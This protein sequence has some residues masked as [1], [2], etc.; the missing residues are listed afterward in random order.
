[1]DVLLRWLYHDETL[2]EIALH[3]NL[4]YVRIR[5]L[6]MK[7]L[8]TLRGIVYPLLREIDHPT[9]APPPDR[10]D[11]MERQEL[12]IREMNAE[13]RYRARLTD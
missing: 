11:P 9:D 10:P 1:M 5:Q 3:L 12:R 13:I 7:A 4:S 6:H 8:N 2:D